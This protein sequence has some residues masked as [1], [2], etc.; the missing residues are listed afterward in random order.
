VRQRWGFWISGLALEAEDADGRRLLFVGLGSG[1]VSNDH[2]PRYEFLFAAAPGTDRFELISR[3]RWFVDIAGVE[4]FE[5][6]VVY[7][8]F[9]VAALV[10]VFGGVAIIVIAGGFQRSP[11]E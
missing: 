2:Y 7:P 8:F 5:W 11:R 4:G 6:Y 1:Q 9:F 10:L 3:N